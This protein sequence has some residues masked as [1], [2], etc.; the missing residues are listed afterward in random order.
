MYYI[1]RKN[2]EINKKRKMLILIPKDILPEII[3]EKNEL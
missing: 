1:L 2:V 3:E